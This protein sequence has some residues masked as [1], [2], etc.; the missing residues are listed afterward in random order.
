MNNA[1]ADFCTEYF[2]LDDSLKVNMARQLRA[3]KKIEKSRE[4][5]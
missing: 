1:E 4:I 3:K 2:R 5:V